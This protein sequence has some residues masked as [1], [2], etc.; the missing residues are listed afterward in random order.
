MLPGFHPDRFSRITMVGYF[1]SQASVGPT[2]QEERK[3]TDRT[4]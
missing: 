3:T 2:Q 1:L 4:H